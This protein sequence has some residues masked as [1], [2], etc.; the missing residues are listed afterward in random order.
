MND[1]T[2][3]PVDE[4]YTTYK[5]DSNLN[6]NVKYPNDPDFDYFAKLVLLD[7]D[8][9]AEKDLSNNHAFIIR[10]PQPINKTIKSEW[11][12]FSSKFGRSL[13]DDTQQHRFSCKNGCTQG[14]FFAVPDD[15][16]FR[17]PI[18]GTEVKL[19]GDDFTF[20]G[21]IHLKDE[22]AV[23]HPTLYYV[24]ESLIG[25]DNL[26]NII[27]PAVEQDA[28][29]N[30]MSM[31]DKRIF[32]KKNARRYKKKTKL[33]TKFESIGLIGLRQKFQEVIDYFYK[34][35]TAKKPLYDLIM[36][37]K[38]KVFIHNI[39]VY[40]TQLR[41]AKVENKR[42]TF[43]KTNA[44]FNLLAALAA[45]IN[46]DNLS[47]YRNIKYQ[48]QVLWDMQLKLMSLATEIHN[49][50]TGKKG[51]MRS[52]I[53]G[54]TAFSSR[55]VIVPDPEMRCDQVSL[56]YFSLVL[57]LEQII[58]NILQSSYNITYTE[59]YKMWYYAT[60]RI[61]QRV[62]DIINN[63]IKMDKI[64]V[65]INRNPTIFY[66]SIVWK[67]VVKCNTDSI[68]MGLDQF[69]LTGLT[70]DFDGDVLNVKLLLNKNFDKICE[71]VYSPRNAFFIERNYGLANPD[72]I[73]F[74]DT[75]INMNAFVNISRKYY[76]SADIANIK[77]LQ[78]KY[79]EVM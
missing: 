41:I 72:T 58:I 13:Q 10:E 4:E 8:K 49:I 17:C 25:K 15:A 20:F 28:N 31:Y 43:E 47:V 16:N 68:V 48:N 57:L 21:Y 22:Y 62:L 63:L 55:I 38:E 18:C 11:G 2:N 7:L 29:G 40:T 50:L 35:K 12:I 9:E 65:L 77:A 26:A 45:K 69:V 51:T 42:F 34:K 79:K 1:L 56:P 3:V 54:R 46:K 73:P 39:P 74:K 24:L 60:L 32:K 30:P 37:N 71:A 33:D 70:A 67:R 52:T 14:A 76:S 64:H 27:E 61:D 23:I 44:D 19:V 53:S 66:Q 59:S 36:K 78:A 5:D 75:L 6:V